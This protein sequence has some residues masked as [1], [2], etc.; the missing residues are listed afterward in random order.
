M[1]FIIP[2]K[3]II[4][5]NL[6]K[7]HRVGGQN[8][9]KIKSLFILAAL[10]LAACGNNSID[11]DTHSEIIALTEKELNSI[12]GEKDQNI[13]PENF[14]KLILYGVPPTKRGKHTLSK[15]RHDKSRFSIR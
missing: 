2:T 6:G 3:C 5:Y 12:G 13:T 1:I 9:R 8:M 4:W 10:S 7:Y 15:F 11:I 14:K